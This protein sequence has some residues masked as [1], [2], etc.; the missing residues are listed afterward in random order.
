M[1][2]SSFKRENMLNNDSLI[3][4]VNYSPFINFPKLDLD[5]FD[6]FGEKYFNEFLKSNAK[7][8]F[9]SKHLH[10]QSEDE[11]RFVN[12]NDKKFCT[13]QNSIKGIILGHEFDKNLLELLRKVKPESTWI[14]RITIQDGTLY[15]IPDE[16][17]ADN[18]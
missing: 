3:D 11:V 1:H 2:K 17:F 5:K 12:F 9:L 14:E 16:M 15:T 18:N 4:S 8:F 10:W 6:S 7:D 13:I